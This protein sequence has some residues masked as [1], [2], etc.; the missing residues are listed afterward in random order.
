[1]G[2]T[3]LASDCLESSVQFTKCG[4]GSSFRAIG[5]LPGRFR[6]ASPSLRALRE[7]GVK[8]TGRA[9]AED[10]N[11]ESHKLELAAPDRRGRRG[12][13]SRYRAASARPSPLAGSDRAIVGA[14]GAGRR[15]FFLRTAER[16]HLRSG[17]VEPPSIGTALC[18]TSTGLAG[19][20]SG[21]ASRRANRAVGRSDFR[22]RTS[23]A[24]TIPEPL[25]IAAHR[26]CT[27]RTGGRRRRL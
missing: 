17:C 3:E 1:M 9:P 19:A 21:A 16:P 4:Q 22:K 25:A 7:N 23:F 14:A 10:R 12:C 27:R 20:R 5:L 26:K 15:V 24:R 18:V 13:S 2:A 6:G 11:F 8:R